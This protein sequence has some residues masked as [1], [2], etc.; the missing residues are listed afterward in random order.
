MFPVDNFTRKRKLFFDETVWGVIHKPCIL[1]QKLS[2]LKKM[3]LLAFFGESKF[4]ASHLKLFVR[5]QLFFS[6]DF[7]QYNSSLKI[8][9]LI[10]ETSKEKLWCFDTLLRFTIVN[11]Q[12]ASWNW[13]RQFSQFSSIKKW[14]CDF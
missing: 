3:M 7:F 10:R 9:G 14:F 13:F 5:P 6:S 8:T 1:K 12:T 4:L 2:Y 11:N